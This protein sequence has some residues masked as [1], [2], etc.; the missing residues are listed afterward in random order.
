M[1]PEPTQSKEMKAAIAY[2]EVEVAEI[3]AEV[4]SWSRWL[5]LVAGTII[6]TTWLTVIILVIP[7]GFVLWK[8]I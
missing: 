2:L 6:A 3:K 4:K 7:L 8:Q 1:I 5:L